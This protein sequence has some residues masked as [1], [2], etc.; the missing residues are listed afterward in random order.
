VVGTAAVL[1]VVLSSGDDGSGSPPDPRAKLPLIE[2]RVEQIRALDFKEPVN[3]RVVSP[4]QVKAEGL[5]ELNRMVPSQL[6]GTNEVLQ[7]LGLLPEGT[8]LRALLASALEQQVA[9]LYDPRLHRLELVRRKGS[10]NATLDEITLAHE[11][12]HALDDQNFRLKDVT[13]VTDDSATAYSALVEGTATAVMQD[14]ARQHVRGLDALGAALASAGAGSTEG[15][16]RYVVDSLAFPYVVGLKFVTRLRALGQG[17]KLVNF[18]FSARPP[19]TSEQVIHP[20][21]YLR[22][23]T[24]VPVGMPPVGALGRGWQRVLAGSF[25]EFDTYELLRSRVDDARARRAAAGWGGGRYALFRRGQYDR[26]CKT[27][28]RATEA[29]AVR[30]HWDSKR[31]AREFAAA[32]RAYAESR[33]GAAVSTTPRDTTLAIAP[34]SAKARTLTR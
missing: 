13:A 1:V 17:W 29:L 2:R 22:G 15:L 6:I 21:A 28:C 18:A 27:P 14:Y 9:G 26:S 20:L 23:E 25:G 10:Q 5:A 33:R 24:A 8:N 7:F 16:P 11:L 34:T 4:A 30:W 19:T 3:A 32:L 31:D 12:D